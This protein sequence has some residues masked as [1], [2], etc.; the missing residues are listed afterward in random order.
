MM[1]GDDFNIYAWQIPDGFAE[2]PPVEGLEMYRNLDNCTTML[3]GHRSIVNHVRYNKKMKAL[4]SCGIEKIVKIWTPYATMDSTINPI[5]RTPQMGGFID[6]VENLDDNV[7]EDP[8]M[9]S[10]FDE[11]SNQTRHETMGGSMHR[12]FLDDSDDSGPF[13]AYVDQVHY[14]DIDDGISGDSDD[15]DDSSASESTGHHPRRTIQFFFQA[16]RR[17]YEAL[18][19]EEMAADR[20]DDG[21][22]G[23]DEATDGRSDAD[24]MDAS[25]AVA[26]AE[27]SEREGG[28]APSREPITRWPPSPSPSPPAV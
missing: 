23:D 19:A 7:D 27:D 16:A 28:D 10:Y 17:R 13:S 1:G 25:G 3:Q 9:L 2:L 15:S 12:G 18:T 26:D 21:A 14:L 22:Q 6:P 4:A 5:L 24:D 8:Q 11:I 20:S